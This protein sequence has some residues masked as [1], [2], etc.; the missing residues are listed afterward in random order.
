MTT[1]S[2]GGTAPNG[3]VV[4][5]SRPRLP[6]ARCGR[7]R[8]GPAASDRGLG[9]TQPVAPFISGAA[10]DVIQAYRDSHG[11]TTPTPAM[12]KQIL[13]S[14]ATDMGRRVRPAGR[15]LLN[16]DAAVNAAR[17]MPGTSVTHSSIPELVD[18]P[19]QVDVQ[20]AG[21]STVHN[22]VTL[23]NVSSNTERV[24]G[25]YRVLG[26]ETSLGRPVTENVSAPAAGATIPAQGA[27]AAA[28]ITSRCRRAPACSMPT[29]AG[30]T[31][32]TTT[33]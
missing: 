19:T 13:T 30:R 14:T 16:I 21:G 22:S 18:T 4:D 33:S 27:T 5:P 9:G 32:P 31:R 3:A 29:C 28:P 10:A 15:C 2:S 23:Y 25:T 8:P 24:T 17:Q 26:S 6:G 7:R 11:G 20:G 12:V 1:L